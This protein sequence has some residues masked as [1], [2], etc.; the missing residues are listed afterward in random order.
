[1]IRTLPLALAVAT[2]MAGAAEAAPK[3]VASIKPVH[4]LVAAVMQ[5]VGEPTL[6]VQGNASPHTYALRPSDAGALEAADVVFWTGEGMELFLTDALAT[7]AADA[8]SI[9]LAGTDGLILLPMREGGAFD[10]HDHGEEAHDHEAEDRHAHG[11]TDMHFWLD[12]QNAKVIVTAIAE[13]LSTTDPEN[14]ATYAANAER[15][16]AEFDALNAELAQTLAPIAGKPFVVFHDAYQY[17]E[18]RFGLTLAGTITVSPDAMPGAQ[19]IG[20]LKARVA[21]LGAT[22]VFA[23][24]QFEP[25]IITAITEGTEAQSGVLDPEGGLLAE[26]PDLYPQLLRGLA[27]ALVECL[28]E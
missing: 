11:E 22:C 28:G 14:A 25:A 23:E 20:E 15:E 9:A 10:E 7:L 17:F 16:L 21:E 6:L 27:A 1:M 19:R 5:G 12:P 26:G 4:S 2:L 3:V 18:N 8:T 24:P 13:T